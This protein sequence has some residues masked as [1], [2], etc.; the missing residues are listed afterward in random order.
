MAVHLEKENSGPL[1]IVNALG[2]AADFSGSH[3]VP[4]WGSEL[5]Y[6]IPSVGKTFFP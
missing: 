5:W 6:L 3:W 1:E 2:H 4:A